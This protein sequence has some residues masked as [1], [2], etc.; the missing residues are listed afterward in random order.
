MSVSGKYEKVNYIAAGK[1]FSSQSIVEC[2]LAD[3]AENN[4]LA[5]SA[6]A[7]F[8]GAEVLPGEVRYG[9]RL[10]FTVLA[11]TPDGGHT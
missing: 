10:Y 1:K 2:R 9:G 8:G 5:V 4:I 6:R 7:V 3:W 11:A